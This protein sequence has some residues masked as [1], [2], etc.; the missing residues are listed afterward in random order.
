MEG[1]PKSVLTVVG[2]L[3]DKN[4]CNVCSAK[5]N[6]RPVNAGDMDVIIFYIFL[7]AQSARPP[8]RP[9]QTPFSLPSAQCS[10]RD[11]RQ[12]SNR[13]PD[14][15]TLQTRNTL[16]CLP[17]QWTHLFSLHSCGSRRG[18]SDFTFTQVESVTHSQTQQWN[19]LMRHMEGLL[20]VV[21]LIFKWVMHTLTIIDYCLFLL[22]F[23][24]TPCSIMTLRN[25]FC[26][27]S[28]AITPETIFYFFKIDCPYD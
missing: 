12:R 7:T 4:T 18:E 21:K 24:A 25:A 14:S 8:S 17:S 9:S 19:L 2:R 11:G 26:A 13:G 10:L 16:Q 28:S 15:N 5:L 27:N 3:Q 22:E 1:P 23:T 20:T 6:I